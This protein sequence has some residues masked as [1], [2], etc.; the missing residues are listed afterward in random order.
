MKRIIL[1]L[2]GR[3]RAAYR[4]ILTWLNSIGVLIALYALANPQS[5]QQIIDAIPQPYRQIAAIAL[6]VAWFWLVQK[7]KAIDAKRQA[8]P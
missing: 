7:G 2:L 4:S 3:V 8:G 5:V 1:C 6:P